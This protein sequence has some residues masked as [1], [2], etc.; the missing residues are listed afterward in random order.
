[1]ENLSPLGFKPS[2][3]TKVI[4]SGRD[5]QTDKNLLFIPEFLILQGDRDKLKMHV[6]IIII[7]LF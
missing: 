2:K 7:A 5:G 6:Y 4:E 3:E 1:M